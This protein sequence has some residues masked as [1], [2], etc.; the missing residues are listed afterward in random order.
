MYADVYICVCVY[1]YMTYIYETVVQG[2]RN[3]ITDNTDV[4]TKE[5]EGEAP[6]RRKQL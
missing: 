1:I 3:T 4:L 6:K 5:K 2:I